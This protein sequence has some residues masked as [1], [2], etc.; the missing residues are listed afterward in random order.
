MQ[1]PSSE[2]PSVTLEEM[3]EVN[4]KSKNIK[5][6]GGTLGRSQTWEAEVCVRAWEM[7]RNLS[8]MYLARKKW[9]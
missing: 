2:V 5:A 4:Q 6:D 8:L 7:G 9:K 1:L 3:E